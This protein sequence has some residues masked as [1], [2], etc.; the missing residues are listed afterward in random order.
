MEAAVAHHV[1]ARAGCRFCKSIRWRCRSASR[2]WSCGIGVEQTAEPLAER[3]QRAAARVPAELFFLLGDAV[4]I[5]ARI[6]AGGDLSGEEADVELGAHRRI[7]LAPPVTPAIG[8][9]GELRSHQPGDV[10]RVPAERQQ[11]ARDQLDAGGL[12]QPVVGFGQNMR[13]AGRQFIQRCPVVARGPQRGMVLRNR[14]ETP[15]K[16]A[17]AA[18]ADTNPSGA[19][20]LFPE[21]GCS[22]RHG[23]RGR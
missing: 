9:V 2:S 17:Q 10:P 19:R 8:R 1:A 15:V 11:A 18:S 22:L 20:C 6:Q 23:G 3:F 21:A 14:V 5:D 4:E 16:A 7:I 13:G 12:E